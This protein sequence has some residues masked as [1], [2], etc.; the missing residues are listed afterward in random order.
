MSIKIPKILF[1]A[2]EIPQSK[3]AG[4]I[5]FLRIFKNYPKNHLLVV[6]RKPKLGAQLL[7]CK[8]LTM[9]FKFWDRLRMTRFNKIVPFLEATGLLKYRINHKVIRS[10]N[11]F[12]PDIVV[13]I[14]QLYSYYSS[15]Y[16]YAKNSN[17][18]F[19][20]FCHDDVESF[21][22]VNL[23]LLNNLIKRNATIYQF[24]QKRFCIS[25]QM[26]EAWDLKYGALGEV[27]YPISDNELQQKNI[28]SDFSKKSNKL[29]FGYAGSLAYG[30]AEGIREL[31]SNLEST[32]TNLNIY[33]QPNNILPDGISKNIIFCGYAE[34]PLITWE[35]IQKECDAVILPYSFEIKFKKLYETHFPS[36]LID[37]LSLGM[38]VIVVGPKYATGL[39]WA[40]ENVDAVIAISTLEKD[41]FKYCIQKLIDDPNLRYEL[42]KKA[43]IKRNVFFRNELTKEQLLNLFN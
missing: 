39:I 23:I 24:A 5:Q 34:T 26:V 35:K 6:G 4:S 16:R 36:K 31:I 14:M 29:T 37:Y 10:I 13:S 7:D 41:V 38:P 18:P 12:K 43:L 28:G 30:Y 27:F 8:Y 19:Y 22:G 2:D 1:L 21:S 42:S 9:E 17:L 33:N 25:K 11:E 15:A 40:C 20:I 32:N 3:G